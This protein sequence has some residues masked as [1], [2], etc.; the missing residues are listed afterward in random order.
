[1]DTEKNF[2][3]QTPHLEFS[4][5]PEVLNE[6][7]GKKIT[8]LPS[9]E[10]GSAI[11]LMADGEPKNFFLTQNAI[12]PCPIARNLRRSGSPNSDPV[13][14]RGEWDFSRG[15]LNYSGPHFKNHAFID[16]SPHEIGILTQ[17]EFNPKGVGGMPTVIFAVEYTQSSSGLLNQNL[18]VK[19]AFFDNPEN[20]FH[21]RFDE[22]LYLTPD[23]HQNQLP[24]GITCEVSFNDEKEEYEFVLEDLDPKSRLSLKGSIA[25]VGSLSVEDLRK[26]MRMEKGLFKVSLQLTALPDGYTTY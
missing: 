5:E 8:R 25:K 6:I 10:G 21:L 3:S 2:H 13:I 20:F 24:K 26:Q 19:I 1:M 18:V 11:V 12:I 9:L 4:V 16:Y 7:L 14:T 22:S 15:I 17:G 23:S